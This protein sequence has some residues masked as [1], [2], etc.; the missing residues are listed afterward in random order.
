MQSRRIAR[1]LLTSVLLALQPDY[2]TPAKNLFSSAFK[3]SVN[4]FVRFLYT[5][6]KCK[7]C[8]RLFKDSCFL[9]TVVVLHDPAGLS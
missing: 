8:I 9:F 1:K 2:R 5:R 7:H 3:N 6:R 4:V